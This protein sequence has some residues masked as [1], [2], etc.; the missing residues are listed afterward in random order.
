MSSFDIITGAVDADLMALMREADAASGRIDIVGGVI[1][2]GD[3]PQLAQRIRARNAVLVNRDVAYK[4]REYP[5]GFDS[6]VAV[7]A[8]LVAT[9]TSQ[10]QI[11]FRV[12]RLVVPS[13]I[14]GSFVLEDF[15]VGKNPQLANSTPVPARVFDERA[16]G[17]RLSGDTAQVSQN[18]TIRCQNIS[19]AGVR[20]RAAVIGSALD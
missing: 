10:P 11:P 15:I 4:L 2:A 12:E 8:G 5:L 1:P 19:G 13:D 7:G 6:G 14:A 3:D 17:V 16:V 9:I 18:V 20:F